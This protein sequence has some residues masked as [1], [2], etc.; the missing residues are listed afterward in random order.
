MRFFDN[1]TMALIIC[2]LLGATV[3]LYEDVTWKESI[4]LNL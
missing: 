3:N 2:Y 1:K 4:F